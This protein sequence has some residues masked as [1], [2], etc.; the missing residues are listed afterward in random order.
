M[1]LNKKDCL[2]L[3]FFLL[4]W[5]LG[6]CFGERGW[7]WGLGGVVW[8]GVWFGFFDKCLKSRKNKLPRAELCWNSSRR[9]CLRN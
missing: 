7:L 8:G 2:G 9:G 3:G 4:V 5:G 6:G 1:S